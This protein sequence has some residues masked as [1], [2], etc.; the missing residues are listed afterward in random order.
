MWRLRGMLDKLLMGVGTTRG[1][2]SSSTLRVNDVVDFWRVES[3]QKN[4]M[5]LLR[6]EM[7]LPGLAWLKFS[8]E[9]DN[10][11]NRL[12]VVAYYDTDTWYGKL[13]WYVF[14]PFHGY[15]FDRLVSKISERSLEPD[16]N[17]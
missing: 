4:R 17:Q 2:R 13:Y 8:I 7:K 5:V 12:S 15:L 11:R 16:K 3:L 6:A 9:P 14:L 1:R 10:G